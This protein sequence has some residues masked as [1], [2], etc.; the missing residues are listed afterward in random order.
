ME[1]DENIHQAGGHPE[2]PQVLL[3]IPW[4]H[5][6]LIINKLKQIDEAFFYVNK[7]VENN[8]SRNILE[9]QI[10]NNLH[11]RQGKAVSNFETT[12]PAYHSDLATETL[13]NPYVFDFLTLEENVQEQELERRLTDNI[14]QL[15]LELGKGFAYLG[16]QY[17]IFIGG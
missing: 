5:H 11:K 9:L 1:S 4:R 17:P 10:R 3:Q 7:V 8:W 13:K 2:I 14:T 15:L 12:L 6:V 16:R